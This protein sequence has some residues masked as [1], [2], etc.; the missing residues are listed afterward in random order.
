MLMMDTGKRL[1]AKKEKPEK[2]WCLWLHLG[3][4]K[5]PGF[6]SK[7]F[8]LPLC[9]CSTLFQSKSA[10]CSSDKF[11]VTLTRRQTKHRQKPMYQA[12]LKAK[13]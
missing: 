1:R 5:L 13:D 4:E 2:V 3:N 11:T 7:T 6:L 10:E 8:F 12:M 9:I